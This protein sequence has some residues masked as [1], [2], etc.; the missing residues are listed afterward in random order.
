[1][2]RC[3]VSDIIEEIAANAEDSGIC[4]STP[5]GRARIITDLNTTLKIMMK[6]CDTDGALWWWPIPCA[7]GCFGLPEDCLEARQV[8][9]DGSGT[10]QRDKFYQGQLSM[11]LNNCGTQCCR[12]EI[13]DMGDFAIPIPLP[14]Y[15]PIYITL[16]AESNADAGV[17][18][19][20]EIVNKYGERHRETLAMAADMGYVKM[21]E[22]ATDVTYLG[23]PQTNGAIRMYLTYDNGQRYHFCDYGPK[24]QSGAFRRKKLPVRC[25]N[26]NLVRVFGKMRQYNITNEN[27]LIAICDTAA[28]SWGMSAVTALRRKDVAGYSAMLTMAMQEV[29]KGLEEKD[30]ASN[31]HPITFLMG[32]CSDSQAGGRKSWN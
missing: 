14:N 30:S 4:A 13:I 2:N 23:K 9:V 25:S 3:K 10:I 24:V 16:A 31:V 7:G 8:F 29:Y 18:V 17:Q 11:G 19:G 32:T 5:E 28:L 1:M 12:P 20:V 15:R 26:S 27:D 22:G 21:E 6:R